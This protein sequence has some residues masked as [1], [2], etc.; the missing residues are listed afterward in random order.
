M[1]NYQVVQ[2]REDYFIF[3]IVKSQNE[4][5]L[6]QFEKDIV[7]IKNE[8]KQVNIKLQ[9]VKSLIGNW[10]NK[11]MPFVPYEKYI[12]NDFFQKKFT[13]QIVSGI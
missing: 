9:Y 11:T 13:N 2:N 5:D 8:L 7:R 12:S 10:N 4:E 6:P 1:K 3:L